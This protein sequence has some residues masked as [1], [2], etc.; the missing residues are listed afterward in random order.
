MEK[1][2]LWSV[3]K[4]P[5]GKLK[6]EDVPDL[7]NTDTEQLIEDLLIASPEL[8][9]DEL[10]LIGRQI[11]TN[12]GPL[13]LLGVDEEGGLVVFELKRGTLTRDAIRGAAGMAA[14]M[15]RASSN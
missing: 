4:D 3:M 5:D 8:L 7:H 13:D 2:K 6:A 1:V 9:M 11:P 14:S 12:G 10:S 15:G